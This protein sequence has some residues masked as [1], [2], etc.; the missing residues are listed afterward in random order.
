[1]FNAVGGAQNLN[2]LPDVLVVTD[3]QWQATALK[4]AR[5]VR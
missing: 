4:E 2:G 5:Q 1:M 3:P